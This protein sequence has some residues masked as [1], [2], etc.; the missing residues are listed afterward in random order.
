MARSRMTNY[1]NPGEDAHVDLIE[2][3]LKAKNQEMLVAKLRTNDFRFFTMNNHQNSIPKGVAL[4]LKRHSVMLRKLNNA[5]ELVDEQYDTELAFVIK[6]TPPHKPFVYVYLRGKLYLKIRMDH[7]QKKEIN[8][9]KVRAGYKFP[10]E[11][12]HAERKDWRDINN[13]IDNPRA[14]LKPTQEQKDFYFHWKPKIII[15]IK[16]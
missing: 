15:T 8:F 7:E 6:L 10:K 2:T 9:K 14:R 16:K 11:M 12:S 13:R 5:A 1:K 4:K 3:H